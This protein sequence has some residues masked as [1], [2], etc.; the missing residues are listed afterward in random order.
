MTLDPIIQRFLQ[1]LERAG[2]TPPER[3]SVA[4]ARRQQSEMQAVE[5]AK[6]PADLEDRSLPVGP[7]GDVSVLLMR[8]AGVRGEL[9]GVVYLHGGGW[10]VGGK[11]THDRLVRQIAHGAGTAVV[12]VD[13]ERSPEA[14]YPVALEQSYAV[15]RWL[16]EHGRDLGIDPESLSVLGDSSG[17]NLAAAITLLAKERDG[18]KIACQALLLPTVDAGFDT[19]S[20]REFAAGP[21]LTR[22]LMEWFW[23][24]YAPDRAAR[25][26]PSAAPLR[27]DLDQLKGLPPALVLTAENDPLRDEGE[28][29][30]RKLMKAGVP[31]TATRYLGT[32]HAFV[33]LNALAETPAA[34][35]AVAQVC[36]FLR[37]CHAR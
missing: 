26:K 14:R 25:V 37:E 30:A 22:P 4:E 36:T 28:A 20:Y 9:P 24:H 12:F 13:Y 2:G 6:L 35:A 29:Y 5:V 21:F 8:P 15:T 23:D 17:G 10:V 27:A 19:P 7:T 3:L 33:L 18:P 11:D 34:R 16:A 1:E 32:I 31:V